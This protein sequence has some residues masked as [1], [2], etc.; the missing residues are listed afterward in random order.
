MPHVPGQNS[1]TV[2]LRCGGYRNILES[3]LAGTSVIENL[4]G[5][6]RAAEVEWQ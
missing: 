3:R 1:E 2:D 4:T 6:M 5:G